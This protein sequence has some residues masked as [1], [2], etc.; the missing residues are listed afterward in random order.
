MNICSKQSQAMAR[1][2]TARKIVFDL[3]E[4]IYKPLAVPI[5]IYRS[6]ENFFD[7]EEC[8]R[9]GLGWKHVALE[10]YEV[11]DVPGGHLTMLARP[12]VGVLAGH[13]SRAMDR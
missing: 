2:V 7:T 3:E 9:G 10:G 1:P 5:T 11:I 6:N 8:I 12:H 4:R 13:M